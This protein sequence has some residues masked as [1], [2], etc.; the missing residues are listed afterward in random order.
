MRRNLLKCFP[1]FLF[2]VLF[3]QFVYGQAPR[4]PLGQSRPGQSIGQQNFYLAGRVVYGDNMEPAPRVPV[5]LINSAGAVIG[6][7]FTD[8]RGEFSFDMLPRA[9][10][11]V[12]VSK[13]GYSPVRTRV[14]LHLGSR[15]DATIFLQPES[16]LVRRNSE[17][18][19]SVRNLKAPPKAREAFQKGMRELHEKKRIDRSIGYF[20]EAIKIYPDYDAAY[21]Q[22]SMAHLQRDDTEE[23]RQVL[24]QAVER[25]SEN[26]ETLTLLGYVY[27]RQGSLE[28]ALEA[29]EKAVKKDEDSWLANMELGKTLF[30]M[31]RMEEANKY[32][33]RAHELNGK[34]FSVH[35]LRYNIAL[36]QKHYQLALNELEEFLEL[37]PDH[38][39]ASKVREQRE[40][41]KKSLSRPSK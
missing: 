6:M 26:A 14:D 15:R 25:N 1:L 21:L 24:E 17:D 11:S 4:P 19:V 16:K 3:S 27:N 22:L 8:E 23:A 20:R 37:F 31:K 41:L 33:R 2:F 7:T 39:L 38:P 32:A 30:G 29:L 18:T 28:K 5:T 13:E 9:V 34:I 10:Y 12:V 36:A 35:L 40:L